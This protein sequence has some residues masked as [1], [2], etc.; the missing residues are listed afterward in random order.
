MT[1]LNLVTL[2]LL[3]QQPCVNGRILESDSDRPVV[4]ATVSAAWTEVRADKKHGVEQIR[5]AKDTT[6]D[7]EGRYHICAIAGAEAL[8]QVRFHQSNAYYPVAVPATDTAARDIRVS[9]NDE[10][11]RG[12]IAGRVLSETGQPVPNATIT[13]LGTASTVRTSSDGTYAMR[14]LPVGS[15]VLIAR[16]IGRGAAV[17]AVDLSEHEPAS[18]S[19]TMQQLPPTLAVVDIVADRLQLGTVYREVGFT[20]RQRMG[21]GHFLTYDQLQYRAAMNTPELFRGVPGVRVVDDH[22][23]TFRLFSDRGPSTIYG[24]GDCT[25]YVIDGTLIGQGKANDPINPLTNE[26]VGGPD[27]LMLPAPNE[28]I[29][30][31]IYQPSEPSPYVNMGPATRCMKVILW[32][33]AQLAGK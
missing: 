25:A 10:N 19:V 18:V 4:G 12:S 30:A 13:I 27:E 11:E 7:A 28:I 15:Q 21:N 16:S 29:A 17:V 26:P 8:I 31:E 23:G 5:V 6:T 2:G 32:T 9:P 14:E 33:K 3:L 1:I 24:H 20:R 22:N